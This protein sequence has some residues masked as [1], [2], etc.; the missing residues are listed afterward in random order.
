[1]SGPF[2]RIPIAIGSGSPTMK[3]ERWHEVDGRY[4]CSARFQTVNLLA[5]RHVLVASCQDSNQH[6]LGSA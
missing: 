2:R 1:M 6:R 3:A 5:G 4:V